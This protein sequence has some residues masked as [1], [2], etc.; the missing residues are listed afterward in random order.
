MLYWLAH[1]FQGQYHALRV[2]QYLTLRSILASLTAL[3][4]GLLCGPIMIRWLHN[5]QI[6]QMVR[7][8]GPQ[9]AFG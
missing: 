2:F 8:D 3:M 6:G 7:D 9:V 1:L 4:V 5:L